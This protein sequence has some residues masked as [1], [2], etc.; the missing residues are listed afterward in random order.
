MDEQDYLNIK[1]AL[2]RAE[3]VL[4]SA[5]EQARAVSY[6][7]GSRQ[8]AALLMAERYYTAAHADRRAA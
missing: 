3:R 4:S 5:Y 1:A 8:M 7:P 2:H 6:R